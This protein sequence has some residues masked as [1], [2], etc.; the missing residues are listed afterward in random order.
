M[1]ET[2]YAGERRAEK[3]AVAREAARPTLGW[4]TK[5]AGVSWQRLGA[6]RAYRGSRCSS[7]W[8]SHLDRMEGALSSCPPIFFRCL[9][10][11]ELSWSQVTW[12][13]GEI[14]PVGSAS[15]GSRPS[16]GKAATELEANR[17]RLFSGEREKNVKSLFH[18]FQKINFRSIKNLNIRHKRIKVLRK[19]GRI[20]L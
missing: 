14:Q 2:G 7:F 10:W 8:R 5:C 6:Q 1:L 13:Q 3:P 16:W 12:W 4:R 20:W 15:M 9:L 19:Y 11:T 17:P 18:G